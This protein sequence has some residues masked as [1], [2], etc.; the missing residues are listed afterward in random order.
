MRASTEALEH[1]IRAEQPLHPHLPLACNHKFH[2]FI[3]KLYFMVR[4]ISLL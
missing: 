4:T 1:C 3:K 2:K